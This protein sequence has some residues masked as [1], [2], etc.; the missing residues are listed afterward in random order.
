MASRA[1]SRFLLDLRR[2]AAGSPAAAGLRG[3]LT[4]RSIGIATLKQE[5]WPT[6]VSRD[7]DVIAWVDSTHATRPLKMH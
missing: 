2:A 7:F 3:E 5:F 4:L 1:P 6:V